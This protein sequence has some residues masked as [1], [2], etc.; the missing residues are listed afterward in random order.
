MDLRGAGPTD[1]SGCPFLVQRDPQVRAKPGSPRPCPRPAGGSGTFRGDCTCQFFHVTYSLTFE[2]RASEGV[3]LD[4]QIPDY[5]GFIL[6]FPK[7]FSQ[8]W[9]VVTHSLP[10]RMAPADAA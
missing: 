9:R 1:G 6:G 5:G 7:R 10:A 8:L 2:L 4:P 3:F